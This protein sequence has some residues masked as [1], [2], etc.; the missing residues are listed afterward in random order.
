ML[1]G[2]HRGFISWLSIFLPCQVVCS[3]PDTVDHC[4]PLRCLRGDKTPPS[5]IKFYILCSELTQEIYLII[6]VA[7]S[8]ICLLGFFFFICPE[9]FLTLN[10]LWHFL[11]YVSVCDFLWIEINPIHQGS[12]LH[13]PVSQIWNFDN[14]EIM[15]VRISFLVLQPH[16]STL[17]CLIFFLL[18]N[19]GHQG[20]Y[21]ENILCLSQKFW[22]LKVKDWAGP[23]VQSLPYPAAVS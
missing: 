15:W 6:F 16:T 23:L 20:F 17:I 3:A 7:F 21:N 8:S 18:K 12:I 9:V 5:V 1:Y 10:N 22:R 13:H 19:T 11:P 2:G 14:R 4:K